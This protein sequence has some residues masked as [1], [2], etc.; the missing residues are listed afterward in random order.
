MISKQVKEA[1]FLVDVN[2]PK[3]FSFFNSP[4]F[5][6]VM[7]IDST[8]K[9]KDIWEFAIKHSLTI[10]TKDTDFYEMFL[11]KE[12]HPKVVSF[13]FGNFTLG[14]LYQ[15]FTSNWNIILRLLE[16]SEF[17]LAYEDKIKAIK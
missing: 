6:H 16:E 8:L 7:D 3:K 15:Y 17:I 10:L 9:D 2:L 5:I 1:R 11:T 4:D 13:R 14:D 12:Q